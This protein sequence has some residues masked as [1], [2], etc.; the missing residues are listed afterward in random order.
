E[1]WASIKLQNISRKLMIISSLNISLVFIP[2]F[3]SGL[4]F[5]SRLILRKHVGNIDIRIA[6]VVDISDV[7]TH[8]VE[9]D[10][11]KVFFEAFIKGSIMIVQIEIIPLK[12]IIRHVD[13]RPTIFID[14]GDGHAESKTNFARVNMC[15][16]SDICKMISVI[17][18]KFVSSIWIRNVSLIFD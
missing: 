2:I 7:G 15:L 14:V 1:E 18:I 12:K 17:A 6:I 9:A 13:I 8:R 3:K 5:D 11:P 16:R 4:R 10:F